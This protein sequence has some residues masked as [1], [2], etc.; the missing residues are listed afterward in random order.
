MRFL[1]IAIILVIISYQYLKTTWK[2]FISENELTELITEIKLS[3]KLPIE[4][5]ALYEKEYPNSLNYSYDKI[6]IKN[7]FTKENYKSPSSIL[8]IMSRYPF[9]NY[10]DSRLIKPREYILSSKLEENVTQ[11]ECL[12]WIVK[13]YDFT[14][15]NKGIY[16]ASEFYFHKEFKSLNE[17]EM[18]GIIILMKNPRFYNPFRRKEKFKEK[19]NELINK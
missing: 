18:A 15:G 8:S 7:L 9:R 13:N 19:V 16:K 6:L 4:F 14:T 1:L 11:K 12:N 17:K 2:D 5:Y 10:K 3:E